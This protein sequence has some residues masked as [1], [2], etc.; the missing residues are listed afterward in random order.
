[1]ADRSSNPSPHPLNYAQSSVAA[2]PRALARKIVVPLGL[3][4]ALCI[5][6]VAV[7]THIAH[8]LALT[9]T[10]IGVWVFLCSFTWW[11]LHRHVINP[12]SRLVEFVQSTRHDSKTPLPKLPADD[13]LGLLAR[14]IDSALTLA[15][16]SQRRM[17]ETESIFRDLT[18]HLNHILWVSDPTRSRYSYVSPAYADVFKRT[19]ENLPYSNQEWLD[20]IHPDDRARWVNNN[21]EQLPHGKCEQTY[22]IRLP[23][24]TLRWLRD[25]AY[26][27]HD[28]HGQTLRIVGVTE[29]ITEHINAEE[30]FRVLF[31]HSLVPQ[32]LLHAHRIIDCN[33]AA[34]DFLKAR[35]K[36]Q[37]IGVP[38]SRL[39]P[40]LQP[41]GSPSA[42]AYARLDEQTSEHGQRRFEWLLQNLHGEAT[43]VEITQTQ[44]SISARTVLHL[45]WHDI[46]ERRRTQ[47]ALLQAKVE[48]EAASRAKSEFL[49]TMSHEIRT[50]MNGVIGFTDLLLTTPLNPEQQRYTNTLKSSAESLLVLINDILDFSKI[51]AGKLTL[52]QTVFPLRTTI[53][54]ALLLLNS[55]AA[56]KNLNL[57]ATYSPDTPELHLGD[58]TRIRQIILNLSGNAL[59]FTARGHVRLSTQV[60]GDSDSPH[61][62]VSIE[63]TGIGIPFE[64]QKNLFQKF[65][66]ADSST[67]RKFGGT[68]LGLSISKCLVELMGGQI[69]FES[70]PN[71]GST[72][73]FTLPIT[74]CALPS[75]KED[76]SLRSSASDLTPA[77]SDL[78]P[79]SGE[80][81]LIL[82]VDDNEANQLLAQSLLKKLG[83]ASDLATDG[84]QA[85][86]AFKA[87]TYALVLMDC[88][89]PEMDG[90]AATAEINR[91]Q[92][93]AP[94]RIPIIALTANA[95]TG[96]REKCLAAGMDDY[97]TKPI[98]K[99]ELHRLLLHWLPAQNSP[100]ERAKT[101]DN[102]VNAAPSPAA[103]H[104]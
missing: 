40:A 69:G 87:K 44:F 66:Q 51:E 22:R 91:L 8:P 27:I 43:H 93:T 4:G 52:E 95:I 45:S 63:D 81:A 76:R 79:Q 16:A 20:A 98:R 55:R 86:A 84:H 25:R 104:A 35:N 65:V 61:L 77:A 33:P 94:R 64:K 36:S 99:A 70:T 47:A 62:K 103:H 82:V 53:D 60:V 73:W 85:I 42:D 59:K 29:D 90:Y 101:N 39:H 88:Q 7:V 14:A 21:L 26:T 24:D 10:R 6:A 12:V 100:L 97:L 54:E 11:L 18:S 74:A 13:E 80:A 71:Q 92:A 49:A 83:Y 9:V 3:A 37:L 46:S 56:E 15:G 57:S 89:M 28:P 17:L 68:G 2:F 50:P 75:S 19:A 38:I 72:F 48:A 5:A 1:M 102:I 41:D 31:S 32:L 34:I 30:R 67:T 78:S 58:P 23:D 96:D